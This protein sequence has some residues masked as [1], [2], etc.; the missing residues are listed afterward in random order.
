VKNHRQCRPSR[1]P[2]PWRQSQEDCR[3]PQQPSV[4]ARRQ[5]TFVLTTTTCLP[6]TLVSLSILLHSIRSP[7]T[8]LTSSRQTLLSSQPSP[9]AKSHPSTTPF[10]TC[11]PQRILLPRIT[12][13]TL[14]SHQLF[15]TTF[16]G[17]SQSSSTTL[18]TNPQTRNCPTQWGQAVHGGITQLQSRFRTL[19]PLGGAVPCLWARREGC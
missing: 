8:S 16:A 9:L 18:P 15:N 19:G 4:R 6:P 7:W 12:T 1:G 17:R 3:V 13:P 2:R 11:F 5:G 14:C 10:S